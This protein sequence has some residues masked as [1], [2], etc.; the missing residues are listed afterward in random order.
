MI[1]LQ[2]F[3]SQNSEAGY[4]QIVGDAVAANM[5]MLRIWGGGLYQADSF[6]DVADEMGVLVWQEAMFACAQY[7]RNEAF[8][9]NVRPAPVSPSCSDARQYIVLTI[10]LSTKLHLA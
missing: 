3:H 8:L 6:Y 7:P 9:S 2:I 1:P 4:Q 10:A 5:N